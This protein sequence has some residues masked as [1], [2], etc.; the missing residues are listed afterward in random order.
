MATTEILHFYN[1]CLNAVKMLY[2]LDLRKRFCTSGFW[3]A[4]KIPVSVGLPRKN[5]LS[6]T[7]KPFHGLVTDDDGMYD[8]LTIPLLAG[9]TWATFLLYNSNFKTND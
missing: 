5:Y 4:T 3:I 9:F 8:I 7:I 1:A 2:M 6:K